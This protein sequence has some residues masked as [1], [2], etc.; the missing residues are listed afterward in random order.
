MN[1]LIIIRN[2]AKAQIEKTHTSSGSF[3]SQSRLQAMYLYNPQKVISQFLKNNIYLYARFFV[4]VRQA[5]HCNFMLN[6]YLVSC[7]PQ[8]SKAEAKLGT[9]VSG[10]QKVLASTVFYSK[11]Q[12]DAKLCEE[13]TLLFLPA[14]VPRA[15]QPTFQSLF[16]QTSI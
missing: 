7:F 5:F 16:L 10:L 13:Q 3:K 8:H 12:V 11:L 15:F 1:V 6:K 2:T 9:Q 4:F 14:L